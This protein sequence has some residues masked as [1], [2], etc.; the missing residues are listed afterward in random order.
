MIDTKIL[1][2][3]QAGH[4]IAQ[5]LLYSH[6]YTQYNLHECNQQTL[7]PIDQSKPVKA[8]FNAKNSDT[9]FIGKEVKNLTRTTLDPDLIPTIDDRLLPR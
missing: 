6:I 3:V 5:I 7:L 1:H 4:V 8:E 9:V 2:S